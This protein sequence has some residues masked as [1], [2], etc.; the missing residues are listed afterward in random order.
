ML[1]RSLQRQLHAD[2]A[3]RRITDPDVGPLFGNSSTEGDLG[4]GTIYVLRSNS[5]DPR[6]VEHRDVIH[7]IGVT[8]N[9][10]ET[11]IWVQTLDP[12]H[13]GEIVAALRSAGFSIQKG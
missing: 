10:V 12:D 1:M 7:K 13:E 5:K 8:G 3:G 11:R 2:P 4:S 9:D 6:I